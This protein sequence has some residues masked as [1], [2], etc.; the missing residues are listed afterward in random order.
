MWIEIKLRLKANEFFSGFIL[1][2]MSCKLPGEGLIKKEEKNQNKPFYI[3]TQK[4][5]IEKNN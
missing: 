4:A 3:L 2:Q 1:Q 5:K